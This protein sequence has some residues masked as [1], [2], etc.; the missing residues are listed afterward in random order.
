MYSRFK[1]AAGILVLLIPLL[2][3]SLSNVATPTA[4]SAP[5]ATATQ[6]QSTGTSEGPKIVTGKVTYTNSFFTAGVA[7]PEIILED[8][9]GFVTRNRKFVIP[10]ESQVIGEI[11]SDFYTSPFT[12]SLSLPAE[13]NGTLHDVNHDGKQDQG[14]MVF[15]I[16]Y[17]TNT[18]GD[19]YL[20]RRDQGGGGW[21]SAYASTEVSSDRDTYLE[22]YGGKYLVYAPD[23]KQQFPSGFGADKKLFT[24]DDPIMDLPAG[25]SV[26]DLDQTPF[27]IDRSEKPTIDLFEP[28]AAAED[29]FSKLSYTEAFDK[30]V[31]KF[32][33]EYAWTELKNIG[34]DAKAREFRPRFED[35]E[36]KKDPHA[37]ALA[38]RDFF[39]SIPDTHVGFDQ[40][41]LNDD[42]SQETAGGLGFAMRETDDGKII[43]NFILKD[44]PADKAGMKW[45]AE[46]VSLD[47]KP[48]SDV[49]D[50]TVPWSS[51][52]SNP[53][54]KRLQ[55]LR[56]ALRFKLDKGQVEVKFKNPGGA[57]QT[58]N[59]PVVSERDSFSF[60]SFYAGQSATALPVEFKV[61][62]SGYG[63][64][65]VNSFLDND[66]LSIQVWERAIKY[67]K[68]NNIP[69]V[70]LDMRVN[71]G[72]N[73]WLADQMAAYFFD[74]ETVVGN[75]AF[76]NKGSGDFYMDPGDQQSMIPP[77][78]DLQFSGPVAVLVGP[79][80]VS[81]CEFFSYDMTINN[82][83]M[84]V[85]QYPTEGAGGSVE[86]FMMP[87]NISAQMTY[88]R[89]VD[90]QGNIHLEGK[91]VMPTV[92]VPVT[93]ETLQQQANGVDVVLAAAEKAI[94]QPVGAGVTPSGPPQLMNNDETQ[95]AIKTSAKQFEE[96]AH[97]KYTNNDYL[98]TSKSFTF[99]VSLDKSQDLLWAWGW[100]AKDAA[101]LAGN[102]KNLDVKFTLDG[103]PVAR[104]KFLK[105]DYANQGQQCTAYILG[106]TNWPAGEHHVMTAVTFK[107]KLNDGS[108]DY[109]PGTQ[110]FNYG[111]FIKP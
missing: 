46:I 65:K 100:C 11:T 10:V 59:L 108:S 97:E 99:T 36:Q 24:K 40:T 18:W 4:T 9:G 39:W 111:V 90:A 16:A 96:L 103:Q 93:A 29:D 13:P 80:C 41:L 101:T 87:E 50:A 3:C 66:V 63:Y 53:V 84:I 26:I 5:V 44:G 25:W 95:N 81:A 91:G 54:V 2:A 52:F 86:P 106:L 64:I 92:K 76:Y 88:G 15:A 73:G 83:A 49:V 82:R 45:G 14:V 22:V 7:E 98:D 61:L 78:A 27:T 51:P 1:L 56:Y 43:A 58:K 47:G 19:P 102:L 70:I 31:E 69:G 67:F 94:S 8:E 6:A 48:T 21:S 74:K 55:Q 109:A 72:G 12:Y 20:E 77:R 79:G 38:L 23:D 89:A 17:W 42:F 110:T 28:P 107:T 32:N 85:G 75:K 35:A 30:M 68:D 104:D 105:L 57:E 37:Y 62:P 71:G 34:W 60:S 33:K